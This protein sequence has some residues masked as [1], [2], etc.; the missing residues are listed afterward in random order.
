MSSGVTENTTAAPDLIRLS[1]TAT[2]KTGGR[3]ANMNPGELKIMTGFGSYQPAFLGRALSFHRPVSRGVGSLVHRLMTVVKRPGS[4]RTVST[5]THA[6]CTH[7]VTE[8]GRLVRTRVGRSEK[9]GLLCGVCSTT[10][11]STDASTSHPAKATRHQRKRLGSGDGQVRKLKNQG[12]PV[13]KRR[14]VR[15]S[16]MQHS[17]RFVWL[18]Q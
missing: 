18:F 14:C 13:R 16:G 3:K 4:D 1:T 6:R 9:C 5:S 10:W 17:C 11:G 7:V 2:K 8:Q 12:R 15:W